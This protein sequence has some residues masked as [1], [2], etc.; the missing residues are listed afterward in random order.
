MSWMDIK[1][2]CANLI[3]IATRTNIFYQ[4]KE[5]LIPALI[6]VGKKDEITPVINSFHL[7]E[8][9]ANSVFKVIED[10]G[11]LSNIEKPAEFN[12]TIE[13]FLININAN[14]NE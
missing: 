4:L 7:K 14:N 6:I 8:G 12:K 11:H 10:A 1:G 9:L 2:L 13:D 5:I 3:A